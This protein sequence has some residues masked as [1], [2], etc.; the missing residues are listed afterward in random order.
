MSLPYDRRQSPRAAI[1]WP[2]TIQTADGKLEARLK[3][4]SIE[5]AYIDCEQ[6]LNPRDFVSMTIDP[7]NH[8]SMKITAE[9]MRTDELLSPGI[10]VRFVQMSEKNRHFLF[11][12]I[13]Y[14]LKSK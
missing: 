1:Q 2:A 3:D 4:L 9:V 12:E 13:S 7:P 14:Y 6:P 8:P 5:G 10:G 11:N